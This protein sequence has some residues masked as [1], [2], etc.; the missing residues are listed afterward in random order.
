[1]A[2]E[3][4][5][6]SNYYMLGPHGVQRPNGSDWSASVPQRWAVDYHPSQA[7][8]YPDLRYS[9]LPEARGVQTMGVGE[10]DDYGYEVPA[11]V[12]AAYSIASLAGGALG[13]YHGYKRNDESVGWAIG[14]FF[15]GSILPIFAL[16]IM[17]AQGLGERK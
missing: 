11:A 8:P 7:Y 5:T 4:V 2:E 3:K 13:A 12:R 14:W 10:H 17:F 16:P 1:V 6:M 15:F 9:D